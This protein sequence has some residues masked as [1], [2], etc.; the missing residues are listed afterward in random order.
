MLGGGIPPSPLYFPC[1]K[2]LIILTLIVEEILYKN[3]NKNYL[4]LLIIY[5]SNPT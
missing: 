4:L 1:V 2:G 3:F 5:P